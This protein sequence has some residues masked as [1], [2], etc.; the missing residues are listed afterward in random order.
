MERVMFGAR[1][2]ESSHGPTPIPTTP[3]KLRHGEATWQQQLP[4]ASDLTADLGEDIQFA[5][6]KR[7]SVAVTTTVLKNNQTQA[8]RL[9]KGVAFPDDV[10]GVEIV[11]V[12]NRRVISPAGRRWDSYF[13]RPTRPS[14][15]FAADRDQGTFEDR[16]P[17]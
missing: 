16:E 8:V 9:P 17:M 4:M 7:W 12:G 15:D 5:Y 1:H 2:L 14:E 11:K 3:Q 10:R 13:A 6:T